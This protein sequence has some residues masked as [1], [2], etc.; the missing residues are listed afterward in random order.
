MPGSYHDDWLHHLY[1][2]PDAPGYVE[3]VK[4]FETNQVKH[5][6]DTLDSIP[7][8]DGTMLDN[9]LVL[10]TDEFCHGYAHQHHEVPYT[11]FCGSDRFFEMGRFIEYA[12]PRSNNEL[13]NAIA[14]NAFGIPGDFGD[15][16]YN[17]T[18]L[19]GL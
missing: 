3:G 1:N 5:F 12:S 7:E 9:T 4:I 13:W 10:W 15:P 16:Q 19:S 11:L 6:L 2:K 17:T 8:G 14:Q 18:P